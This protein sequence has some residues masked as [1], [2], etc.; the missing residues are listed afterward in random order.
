MNIILD[1]KSSMKLNENNYQVS[2]IIF[3]AYEGD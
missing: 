3:I 1:C 2:K